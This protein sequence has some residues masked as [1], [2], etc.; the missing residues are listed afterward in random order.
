MCSRSIVLEVVIYTTIRGLFFQLFLCITQ[1]PP[2]ASVCSSLCGQDLGVLALFV[3]MAMQVPLFRVGFSTRTVCFGDRGA[4]YIAVRSWYD[5]YPSCRCC[6]H[7]FTSPFDLDDTGG[8]FDLYRLSL[9]SFHGYNM[10]WSIGV[11]LRQ[12]IAK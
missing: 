9:R 2:I 11:V 8:I 7:A 12:I 5:L 3:T 10:L 1:V 4:S 6:R